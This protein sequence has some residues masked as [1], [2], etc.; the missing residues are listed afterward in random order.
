MSLNVL[1]VSDTMIKD[2]TSIHGNIDPKLLYPEIKVAQDMLIHPILGTALFDK[3]IELVSTGD[4]DLGG[5]VTY[6]NLLNDYIVD[7]L[8][9]YVLAELPISISYQFWNKGVIRKQGDSTELPTMSEL[10]DIS[11]KYRMRAEWYG[12][13]LTKYLKQNADETT[14]TEYITDSGGIDTIVP[15]D[16]NYTMPVYLGHHYNC[17]SLDKNNCNCNN[18]EEY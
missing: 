5:N 7:P 2:R 13:R 1:L 17:V 3:L 18:G 9:Y 12:E 14:L 6:K 15:S 10:I 16:S 11:N 4:I 8:M